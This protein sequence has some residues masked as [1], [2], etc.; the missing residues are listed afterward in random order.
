MATNCVQQ[1]QFESVHARHDQIRNN[2]V[3]VEGTEP[4]QR[5]EAVCG[6]LRH[7]AAVGKNGR[8]RGTLGGVIIC[9]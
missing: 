6:N 1:D 5:F 7:K 2:D 3:R 8:Q 9:D 4:F